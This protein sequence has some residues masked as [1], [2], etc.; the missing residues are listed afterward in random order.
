MNNLPKF[1]TTDQVFVFSALLCLLLTTFP[2]AQGWISRGDFILR[3]TFIVLAF[4]LKPR[5]FLSK[6][7]LFIGLFFLYMIITGSGR[8]T[9]VLIVNIMEFVI[10]LVLA[11][12]FLSSKKNAQSFVACFAIGISIFIMVNTIIVNMTNPGIV[13]AMVGFSAQ[14]DIT[15]GMYYVQLG[16]CGYAFAMISM[17]LVPVFMYMSTMRRKILHILFSLITVYF[18]YISGITTCLMIMIVMIILYLVNRNKYNFQ[19]MSL[20]FI[21]TTFLLYFTGFA[22]IQFLLPY[23]EGTTFYGHFGGLLEFSGQESYTD[24]TYDV[25]GR[26]DLYKYSLDTFLSHPLFGSATGIIG[27]HNYFLDRLAR[28]GIVGTFPLLLFLY[29]RFNA[30]IRVLSNKSKVVYIICITGFFMLGFLKNM[31]GI[32]Y[33]TYMFLYIPCILKYGELTQKEATA[34]NRNRI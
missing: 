18:V 20:T 21:M 1:S 32:D 12:F 29:Y 11:N 30:A 19:T 33:W 34:L 28:M 2:L 26:V 27:G 17:C 31:A 8:G 9:V 4:I 25:E 6:D 13:R 5:L 14:G 24:E 10:P 23:L 7:A 15:Q 22:I 16:V 3:A